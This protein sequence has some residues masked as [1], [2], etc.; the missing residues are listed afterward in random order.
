MVSRWMTMRPNVN[1]F[2]PDIKTSHGKDRAKSESGQDQIGT[3]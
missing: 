2:N 1:Y 3:I